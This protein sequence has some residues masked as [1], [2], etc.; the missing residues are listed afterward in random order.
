MGLKTPLINEIICIQLW[1]LP[2]EPFSM[3]GSK[4]NPIQTFS[5]FRNAWTQ[6]RFWI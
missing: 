1:T 6:L 2:L 4:Q 5:N 3:A